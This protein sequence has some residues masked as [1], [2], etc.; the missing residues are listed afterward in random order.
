MV[1]ALLVT[2]ALVAGSARAAD[3]AN[4]I[5]LVAKPELQDPN[6]A[7]TVVLVTRH[8]GGGAVGVILNRPTSTRLSEVF[9]ERKELAGRPDVLFSGGPVSRGTLVLV[10]RTADHP[11]NSLRVLDDVYM[12]LDASL[13][14][15]V[16]AQPDAAEFHLYAGYAGWGPGQ[17]EAEIHHGGWLVVEPDARTL[18]GMTADKMWPTLHERA[19]GRGLQTDA[20][21]APDLTRQMEATPAASAM[22]ANANAPR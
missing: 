17:L 14:E 16:I 19:M 1:I 3:E 22:T 12:S 21:S 15:R 6:F 18:F 4:A 8:Q 13:F 20:T 5:L 11:A 2:V 7:R 10:F 9:P